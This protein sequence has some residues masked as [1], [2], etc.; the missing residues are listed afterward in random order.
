MYLSVLVIDEFWVLVVLELGMYFV[1]IGSRLEQL[2][3]IYSACFLKVDWNLGFAEIKLLSSEP[4]LATQ[5]MRWVHQRVG[6]FYST[7]LVRCAVGL[8]SWLWR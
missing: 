6:W 5:Y 4:L 3:T 1:C 2:Q 8:R 7:T